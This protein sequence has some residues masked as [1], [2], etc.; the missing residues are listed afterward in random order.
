MEKN[1]KNRIFNDN[2]RDNMKTNDLDVNYKT[3]N[4][5]SNRNSNSNEV[6]NHLPKKKRKVTSANKTPIGI[7]AIKGEKF[8]SYP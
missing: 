8:I 4:Y 3:K 6:L 2:N 7:D 1:F 5:N